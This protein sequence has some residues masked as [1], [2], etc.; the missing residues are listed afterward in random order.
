MDQ[1]VLLRKVSQDLGVAKV[2]PLDVLNF[3]RAPMAEL[4]SK[5]E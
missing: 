4:L 3:E 1:V 5:L 2:R